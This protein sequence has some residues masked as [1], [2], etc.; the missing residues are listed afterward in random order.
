MKRK[1]GSPLWVSI[2][3]KAVRNEE[4]EV[5]YLDGMIED[6]TVKKTA[7]EALQTAKESAEA[8]NRAKSTFLASMSHEIRT[9]LN[10]ITGMIE[11][12]G[13]TDLTEEQAEYVRVLKSSGQAL[14]DLISDILDLSKI[15]AGQVELERTRFDLVDLIEDTVEIVSVRMT[16]KGLYL[17]HETAPGV[18]RFLRGDPI[19][20]RQIL[21]NLLGN[22]A[23]FTETGGV[24]LKLEKVE[25]KE[26][27]VKLRFAV[28]D[29]GI[30]IPADK[31]SIIFDKFSQAEVWGNGAWTLHLEEVGGDDGWKNLGRE[32][33]RQGKHIQL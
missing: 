17:R 22:A 25:E 2:S 18:P 10:A 21:I 4:G 16:K 6:I 11:L 20:L 26:G 24:T 19:R 14:L 15:E 12:L 29:T 33:S 7:E 5:E 1:D 9:P 30:G 23:K 28:A 13:E 3:A 32:P 27:A 8:A 31:Q